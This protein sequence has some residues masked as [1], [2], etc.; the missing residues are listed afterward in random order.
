[1][2][3]KHSP[4]APGVFGTLVRHFF[5]RF[6]DTE[7]LSPQGEP[8]AGVIQTLGILAAPGAFFVL[9]FRPLT[10][11]GWSLVAV[12]YM[13]VSFSMTVMGFLMVF[14]WDAL[15]P[16]LRDYQVLTPQP[17]RLSTLFLA[18]AA[19]L[20]IFLST[21]LV[22]VNF[23]SVLM[24]PGVDGGKDFFGILGAHVTAVL[25]SGLFA[26]LGAAALH[27]VLITCLRGWL[28]RRVSVIVQ[29]LLMALL[30]MNLFLTPMMAFRIQWVALHHAGWLYWFPGF[31]FSGFYEYLRPATRNL[32]L[33]ELGVFATRALCG[34]AGVF[35]LTFLPGYRGHARRALETTA[36]AAAGPGRLRSAFD[37]LMR[38][39]LL[40]H[41][42]EYAVFHFISQTITR[43]LKHR[44]FLATYGGF[45]AAFAVMT[46]GS[47]PSGLL[48]LPLTLSFILVSGL[49]AA[50]N[51]PA[52]LSANW[53]FQLSEITGVEA[54][55]AA[56]RKW[57]VVCAILPVFLL[58]AP[59]EFACFPP[60][61]ALFHLAYGITTSVLLMEVM[62]FGFHKVPFT[63][64][65]LPGKVNLTFLAVIYIFGFSA[66]SSTMSR[67]EARLTQSP[68]AALAF[69]GLAAI[70]CIA[71]SR[72]GRKI[73]GP[74]PVL[75]YE[76]PAEPI[77]RTLGLT[78]R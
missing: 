65:H 18:K 5:S 32:P 35:L 38:R 25:A 12:R 63:C 56:T 64:A 52:E 69:F 60:A 36:P 78:P 15:F 66:Y 44:L 37:G 10:L 39:T 42:V 7:S 23:F 70:L 43:S 26:A 71:V 73:L 61:A 6:F 33:R 9:L 29:T 76:D 40:R 47:G 2:E 55:V 41:P 22:D 31:W 34:A 68:A 57:T 67:L 59:M 54:Y 1:M 14:E 53:A 46:F 45:G 28:Y 74:K 17:V 75:D 13:F 4:R 27:G 77:V 20:A 21:F 48:V 62:F 58:M 72:M 19:A 30:V 51:F 3:R 11:T 24:W 49:R 16:D 50:F 8:E